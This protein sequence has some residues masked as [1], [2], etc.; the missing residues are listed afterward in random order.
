MGVSI[1]V[2]KPHEPRARR[3]RTAF[4]LA[5]FHDP[6]P[7]HHP[8]KLQGSVSGAGELPHEGRPRR[9]RGRAAFGRLR[10]SPAAAEGPGG[11]GCSDS[12]SRPA[13]S[14]RRRSRSCRAARSSTSRKATSSGNMSLD[15]LAQTAQAERRHGL[16]QLRRRGDV[17]A[18]PVEG[19]AHLQPLVTHWYP[20]AFPPRKAVYRMPMGLW[21]RAGH[22][23]MRV[24]S[25]GS[26]SGRRESDDSFHRAPPFHH[27]ARR[28]GRSRRAPLWRRR[29]KLWRGIAS[30]AQAS[31]RLRGRAPGFAPGRATVSDRSPLSSSSVWGEPSRAGPR[32][33]PLLTHDAGASPFDLRRANRRLRQQCA[34]GQRRP[35]LRS[36]QRARCLA[37]AP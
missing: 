4:C 8:G 13:V 26:P 32:A 10:R 3:E 21:C 27:A 30:P 1:S 36:V 2:R 6:L 19:D 18:P 20:R 37:R 17:A 22:G 23:P 9:T 29:A 33:R 14:R 35:M 15:A 31:K 28:R 11:R 7:R 25:F 24:L 5:F 12:R 34:A 16:P